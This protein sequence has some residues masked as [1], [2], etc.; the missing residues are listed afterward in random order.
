[1]NAAHWV[2]AVRREEPAK[3]DRGVLGEVAISGQGGER[4]WGGAGR[5][6]RGGIRT[7]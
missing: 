4:G 6:V 2:V 1:M 5:G 7:G 3:G